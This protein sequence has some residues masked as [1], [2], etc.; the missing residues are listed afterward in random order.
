MTTGKTTALT[1]QE[2]NKSIL[3]KQRGNGIETQKTGKGIVNENGVW[4]VKPEGGKVQR[5][6]R[7][8]S[9]TWPSAPISRPQRLG[10]VGRGGRVSQTSHTDAFFF[11]NYLLFLLVLSS[12]TLGKKKGQDISIKMFYRHLHK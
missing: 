6:G 10:G 8:H 1:R 12:P 9:S 5:E 2:K 11:P 3:D 4:E 7:E